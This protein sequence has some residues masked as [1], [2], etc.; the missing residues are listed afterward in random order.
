[1][2]GCS[3]IFFKSKS[4][5]GKQ[6]G[7]LEFNGFGVITNAERIVQHNSKTNE[8]FVKRWSDKGFTKQIE[9]LSNITGIS[10]A[11]CERLLIEHHSIA[12]IFKSDF[13]AIESE[14]NAS[15]LEK[16]SIFF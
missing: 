13:S 7:Y 11:V 16:L 12:A 8:D 9:L 1:M 5:D 14:L 15:D 4:I 2:L 10:F 3:I 6:K